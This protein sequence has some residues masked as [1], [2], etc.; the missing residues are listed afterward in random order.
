MAVIAVAVIVVAIENEMR[1]T[2]IVA[3]DV[4]FFSGTHDNDSKR[5][6][7]IAHAMYQ[8]HAKAGCLLEMSVWHQP[9]KSDNSGTC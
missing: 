2:A 7:Q 5:R 8:S 6:P 4:N 9:P 1:V 3:A